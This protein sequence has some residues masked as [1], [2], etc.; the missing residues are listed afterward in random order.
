MRHPSFP[1]LLCSIAFVLLLA[2]SKLANLYLL[3]LATPFVF[4]AWCLKKDVKLS[5]KAVLLFNTA[6]IT[7][8]I[9]TVANLV[10]VLT[11]KFSSTQANTYHSL[12]YGALTFSDRPSAHLQYLGIDGDAVQCVNTSAYSLIGSACLAKYRNQMSFYNTIRVIYRE[13]QVMFRM[14]TH[15]FNNMQDVSLEY[16]GK[17]SLDDPRS[18]TSSPV[19]MGVEE[20]FRL[21]TTQAIP[22]NL[23]SEL[24]FKFFPT[25]H[26]LSFTII[27]FIVWFVWVLK[28]SGVQQELAFVGLFSTI[29]CV[30]DM[31]VA[32]LGDGRYEL[33]KHLFL[34]N[35]LFD[36]GA[37]VFSNTVLICCLDLIK[38][39]LKWGFQLVA[40]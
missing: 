4:Y 16:L 9:F 11:T 15:V 5:A 37:I 12:F 7:L 2:T 1:H 23:W 27:G 29:A 32:V 22:L 36:I 28:R 3:P 25:G 24:K 39:K 19:P 20:R 26:A 35:V 8:L 30:A 21:P 6:L 10:S 17:Y 18:K 33:V 13:P 14:L 38:T 34:S 40:A 31:V